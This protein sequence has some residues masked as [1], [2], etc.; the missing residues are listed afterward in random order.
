MDQIGLKDIMNSAKKS[1]LAGGDPMVKELFLKKIQF[2]YCFPNSFSSR[3]LLDQGELARLEET[4]WNPQ[5]T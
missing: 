4:G 1:I 3:L 2:F 5:P